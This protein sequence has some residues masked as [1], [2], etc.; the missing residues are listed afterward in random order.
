MLGTIGPWDFVIIIVVL[1]L[2]FGTARFGRAWRGLKQG[3]KGFTRE[4]RGGKD[5]LPPPPPPSDDA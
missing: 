5:E 4:V 2:I 1:L 3:G